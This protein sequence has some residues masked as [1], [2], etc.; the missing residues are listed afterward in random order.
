[1]AVPAVVEMFGGVRLRV[2]GRDVRLPTRKTAALLAFLA[3]PAGREHPR[4]VLVET[5]WP[6]SE[7]ESGRKSL[8]V[9][10]SALRQALEP[11][12][13]DRGT[14]LRSGRIS[15]S[16]NPELVT[17][18]LGRF[19]QILAHAAKTEDPGKRLE[20]LREATA[21]PAGFFL[22]GN[23][24]D[25]AVTEAD[26]LALR[27]QAA[28]EELSDL[29]EHLGD[30]QGALTAALRVVE[31]DRLS[32]AGYRRLMRLHAAAGNRGEVQ[33]QYR[34]LEQVLRSEM[35][36]APSAETRKL[37]QELAGPR[38]EVAAG[39]AS[40][41]ELRTL[42]FGREAELAEIERLLGS[43]ARL[44]AL[45]GPGGVG[46]T[47]LALEAAHR[48]QARGDR[49]WFVTVAH[50]ETGDRLGRE[51]AQALGAA[52]TGDDDPVEA[53]AEALSGGGLL[54]LDNLEQIL[55]RAENLLSGLLDRCPELTVLATSRRAPALSGS[56]E[57]PVLPLATPEAGPKMRPEDALRF[58][59][60]QLFLS[61]SR[62]L[63]P[64]F[65]ITREN[66]AAIAALC[67]R[68]DGLPLA[69][70]LAAARMR[71]L[72]PAQVLEQIEGTPGL[73]R[74]RSRGARHS[75]LEAAL[76]WSYRLLQP[77]D[78][79][80]FRYLSVFRG[81]C[82]LEG[83]ERVGGGPVLD[84]LAALRDSSLILAEETPAGMR[85]RML[86]TMRDFAAA[87]LDADEAKEARTRHR[88]YLIDVAERTDT[89]EREEV[90]ALAREQPNMWAALE[91][92]CT[93]PGEAEAGLR[94]AGDQGW[95]WGLRGYADQARAQ[96]ERLLELPAA[97]PP[98]LWRAR[99]LMSTGFFERADGDW[100]QA[101]ERFTEALELAET[102][103]REGMIAFASSALGLL[104]ADRG[105]YAAGRARME[106][107]LDYMV[108]NEKVHGRPAVLQSLARI[109]QMQGD[110]AAARSWL[111]EDVTLTAEIGDE[112]CQARA[113]AYLASLAAEEGNHAEARALIEDA[114]AR[115]R[116]LS[117]N[118][119][120]SEYLGLAGHVAL[121][122][123]RLSDAQPL[124][125]E[126][127]DLA[128]E[129]RARRELARALCGQGRL[130]AVEGRLADARRLHAESLQLRIRLKH[131]T[132]VRESLRYAGPLAVPPHEL[133]ANGNHLE[134]GARLL[135]S[136]QLPSNGHYAS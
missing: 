105:N 85:Y 54:V 47:R 22:P 97:P 134:A 92:C 118:G 114:V 59:S 87:R 102:L 35:D 52:V 32:E 91:W 119:A 99:A 125:Q 104:E 116:E 122:D 5:F 76:E 129:S 9:A 56:W 53:I 49:V 111:E 72:T 124:L 128:R 103:E 14:I 1:M 80:F 48:R 60:V 16:L 63:L 36:A 112:R 86:E 127:V 101:A 18:D 117:E 10:L 13:A 51:V 26:R 65:A 132:D 8:G 88:D 39:P 77:E 58:H 37:L 43:G 57:V 106:A 61:R 68:V 126:A 4:E 133:G 24:E 131:R 55:E 31:L 79:R 6:D 94:L 34:L 71:V 66:A 109:A 90:E 95:F 40:L 78:Q 98:S 38:A 69:L 19:E 120:L 96:L 11:D 123:G 67:A 41:P 21:I 7:P 23:Y 113:R 45:T 121:D 3:H 108:R 110:L 2:G 89:H 130:A 115:A 81:G 25:W 29:A 50:V 74:D 15:V 75:S 46:K 70:E 44:V 107:C 83:A 93:E 135:R 100:D 12:E 73:L 17:T 27:L 30:L 62:M 82:T 84:Q 33:R 20:L 42:F 64:S 136:L 28:L